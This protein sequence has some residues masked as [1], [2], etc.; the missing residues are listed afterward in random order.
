MSCSLVKQ[1]PVLL[2]VHPEDGQRAEAGDEDA[3]DDE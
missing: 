3:G 2:Q 1:N